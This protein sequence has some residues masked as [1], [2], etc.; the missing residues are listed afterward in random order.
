VLSER[1][2]FTP[3]SAHTGRDL[4]NKNETDVPTGVPAEC[5]DTINTHVIRQIKD[6]DGIKE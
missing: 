5:L 2:V 6:I 1:H 3:H 4:R